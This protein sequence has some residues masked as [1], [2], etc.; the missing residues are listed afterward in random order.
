MVGSSDF[1]F[2][3]RRAVRVVKTC[4]QCVLVKGIG[5]AVAHIAKMMYT[6]VV[7]FSSY[8]CFKER[9]LLQLS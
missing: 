6:K 7:A 3:T 4:V 9:E 2:A 8:H 1:A 5:A